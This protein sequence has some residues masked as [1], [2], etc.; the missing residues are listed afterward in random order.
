MENNST[1]EFWKRVKTYLYHRKLSLTYRL[2]RDGRASLRALKG[3]QDQYR[4]KRCFILGNGPSLRQTDLSKLRSEYT[5]GLNR[6]YLLFPE[7]GFPTTWLISVNRLVLEQCAA[8]ILALPT[9]KFFPWSFRKELPRQLPEDTHFFLTASG[10]RPFT[11]DPRVPLWQ[12]ATVT[13][14]A[15]QLAY[16]MGFEKVILIGVDHSFT[17]TGPANAEV[18]SQGEDPNHFSPEYFGKGFRWQLPDLE[19]SEYAYKVA[20]EAFISDGREIVDATIGGKLT[21]FPK[22]DYSSLF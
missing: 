15:M 4:G 17:T 9:T 10:R 16:I 7:M 19:A 2:S 12:G 3:L 13:Y 5:F 21:V 1:A 22:V 11:T 20:R 6:I 8:E 14:L 18:T